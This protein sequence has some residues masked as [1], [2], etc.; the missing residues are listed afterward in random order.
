MDESGLQH[1]DDARERDL[2]SWQEAGDRD[3]L[4]RLLR[5]D[6]GELKRRLASR[7]RRRG[8]R[9]SRAS[10]S[11]IAVDAAANVAFART[12]R[13][14]RDREAFRAYV[15]S[16][17][18]H[19][20]LRHLRARARRDALEAGAAG[21]VERST[22]S[23]RAI[24]AAARVEEAEIVRFAVAMLPE[25]MRDVLERLYFRSQSIE[26]MAAEFSTSREAVEMRLARAKKKLRERLAAWKGMLE[27]AAA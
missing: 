22:S 26:S 3:A 6:L 5:E 12:S 11:G 19:L 10:V 14:F 13:P 9:I 23:S 20:L 17:A 21:A 1:A 7:G 15:L 18:W 2:R 4:D 27:P 25:P 8:I 24:R 16:A